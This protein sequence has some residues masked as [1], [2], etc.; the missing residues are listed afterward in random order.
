MNDSLQLDDL[1]INDPRDSALEALEDKAY[2][3]LRAYKG[4]SYLFGRGVYQRLFAF[5]GHV[6]TICSCGLPTIFRGLCA[7]FSARTG[8][9]RRCI[10][11]R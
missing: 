10:P 6:V 8:L 4:N 1:Q 7:N 11:R 9:P 2:Q 3:L 5:Y